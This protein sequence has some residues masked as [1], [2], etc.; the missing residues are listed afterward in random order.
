MHLREGSNQLLAEGV[1]ELGGD[2]LGAVIADL[3]LG[4]LSDPLQSPLAA[5]DLD[6]VMWMTTARHRV[7]I[8]LR[9]C[10]IYR[11]RHSRKKKLI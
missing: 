8:S 10:V 6:S 11:G 5:K 2:G 1:E 4:E 9:L 7:W 3:R